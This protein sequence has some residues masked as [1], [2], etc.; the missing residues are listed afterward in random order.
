MAL[1]SIV[2]KTQLCLIFGRLARNKGASAFSADR[3]RRG[4]C[5]TG[6][7]AWPRPQRIGPCNRRYSFAQT[8]SDQCFCKLFIISP[9][10]FF[11]IIPLLLGSNGAGA[12]GGAPVDGLAGAGATLPLCEHPERKAA[13]TAVG[14]KAKYR[15]LMIIERHQSAD[16][17]SRRATL[18]VAIT[19]LFQRPQI[20]AQ[21]CDLNVGFRR[22]RGPVRSGRKRRR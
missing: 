16:Q 7:A 3:P 12:V 4:N 2:P 8:W 6:A 19:A 1:I 14:S 9:C 21:I 20:L 10:R 18:H 13:R 5:S 22:S 15:L 17:C 11:A